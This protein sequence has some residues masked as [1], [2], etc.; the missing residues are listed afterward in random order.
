MD[1]ILLDQLNVKK[2]TAAVVDAD[3]GTEELDITIPSANA[4][5]VRILFISDS[6]IRNL[7][8]DFNAGSVRQ[9]SGT[10][11]TLLELASPTAEN[12][13]VRFQ[14]E[15]GSQVNVCLLYTSYRMEQQH[16][17]STWV[18][19]SAISIRNNWDVALKNYGIPYVFVQ[20][21]KDFD[22]ILSLIHISLYY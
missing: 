14:G 4:S 11:Y 6:P 1:A 3:G 22:R 9:V 7:V 13:H 21:L 20:R 10:H 12:V 5:T 18:V 17:H 16:L 8:A 15:A 19:S 2:T